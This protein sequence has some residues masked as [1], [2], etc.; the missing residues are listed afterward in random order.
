MPDMGSASS[1]ADREMAERAAD[2]RAGRAEA[3]VVK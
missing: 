1:A 3:G 2:V